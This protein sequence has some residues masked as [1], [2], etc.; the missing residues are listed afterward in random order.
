MPT[1]QNLRTLSGRAWKS[2]CPTWL[3][4]LWVPT[5]PK[6]RDFLNARLSNFSGPSVNTCRSELKKKLWK[7]QT[8]CREHFGKPIVQTLWDFLRVP[9]RKLRDC[10]G[11]P[12]TQMY[13]TFVNSHTPS[14]TPLFVS[15]QR[16]KFK[17]NFVNAHRSKF[18][19]EF[20]CISGNGNHSTFSECLQIQ[21]YL[22]FGNQ[23]SVL[24]FWLFL[25]L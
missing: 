23:F 20:F 6:L 8:K 18:I 24:H 3:Y 16:S 15:G 9:D 19:R 2:A 21:I 1:D 25:I 22:I 7:P 4:T 5:N 17:L 13:C 11:C 10:C 14:F 12:Q